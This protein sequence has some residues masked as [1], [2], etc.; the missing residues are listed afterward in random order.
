MYVNAPWFDS[1][2]I[3][4]VYSITSV[5][6]QSWF[7]R[8]KGALFGVVI[9]IMMIPGS[10]FMLGWNEYRTIH[11]TQGLKQGAELVASLDQVDSID[12]SMDSQLVHLTG[13]A[14]TNDQ[15]KDEDFQIDEQAIKLRRSVEMFQWIEEKTSRQNK[16]I[17]G[18]K[19]TVDTYT[20]G[21][22][23]SADREDSS[24]FEES[25]SHF[26][27]PEKYPAVTQSATHVTVGAFSLGQTL[28]AQIDSFEPIVWD[29]DRI[30]KLDPEFQDH[31]LLDGELI[32]WSAEGKPSLDEPI[33]GDQR[34]MFE[35]VKPTSVSVVAKQAG[36]KL[37]GFKVSNGEKIEKLYVGELTADEM[38]D[39]IQQENMAL[40]WVIR[41]AGFG[42]SCLG[43]YLVM[44]PLAVLADIVPFIGSLTR[45]LTMIIAGLMGVCLSACTVAFAWIAVRPLIGIPMLILAIGCVVMLVRI[46]SSRGKAGTPETDSEFA[47]DPSGKGN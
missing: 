26:N 12:E 41:I 47:F 30:E 37:T 38:F 21:T 27:P 20:Y 33:V 10:V 44:A 9:G 24:K 45:S 1:L 46:I 4:V 2:E 17:G 18:R 13:L 3:L 32:Y 14:E 28:I 39:K 11:R 22:Q 25:G 42:M 43:F 15:L 16:K 23:W 6:S 40:A 5:S 31:V 19:E 35:W 7:S 36:E 29:Q 8:A 34:I